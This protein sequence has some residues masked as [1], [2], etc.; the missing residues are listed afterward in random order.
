MGDEAS[1]S[2]SASKGVN[3]RAC[4]YQK[5]TSPGKTAGIRSLEMPGPMAKTGVRR[6]ATQGQVLG[7]SRKNK[8]N[9]ES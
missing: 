5:G 1:I 4:S 6:S 9:S 2:K 7:V 8:N 3:T